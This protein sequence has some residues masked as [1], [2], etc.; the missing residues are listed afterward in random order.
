MVIPKL[1]FRGDTLFVDGQEVDQF[2][3][4]H[5]SGSTNLKNGLVVLHYTANN[6]M[7][8]T[9]N[10]FQ[11][12]EAEVSAHFVIDKDG[13]IAQGPSPRVKAWHAGK[14]SWKFK[15]GRQVTGTVNPVSVGIEMVKPNGSPP[16]PM[17]Q[18]IMCVLLVRAIHKSFGTK[19]VAGH[20]Q[21][22]PGRKQDPGPSFWTYW[23]KAVSLIDGPSLPKPEPTP[24]PGP[25]PE[26]KPEPTPEVPEIEM[27]EEKIYCPH[28]GDE[29]VIYVEG[30]AKMERA[31]YE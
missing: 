12:P 18:V 16:W 20:D 13:T 9:I 17:E 30:K 29:I 31:D 24:D 23:T 19:E 15:D 14:S 8:G 6:S 26:P 7:S 3:T 28:C 21:V 22:S 25:A 1:E 4:P 5:Q 11:N 2:D 27:R 10:W